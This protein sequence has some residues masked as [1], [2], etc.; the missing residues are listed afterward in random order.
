ME[1]EYCGSD[2][3][4]ITCPNCE[5]HAGEPSTGWICGTCEGHGKIYV[6]LVCAPEMRDE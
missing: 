6:C 5:G 1:C 4:P 3:E 2:L